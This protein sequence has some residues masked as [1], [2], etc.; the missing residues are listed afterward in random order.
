MKGDAILVVSPIFT[1]QCGTARFQS[2]FELRKIAA[3][4]S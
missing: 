1:L 4:G 3:E 2:R